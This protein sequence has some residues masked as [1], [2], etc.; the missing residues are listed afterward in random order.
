MGPDYG[1]YEPPQ[2]TM[3]RCS[4]RQALKFLDS[5]HVDPKKHSVET[6][7]EEYNLDSEKVAKILK[8]FRMHTIKIL[9]DPRQKARAARLK[10]SETK[11][12]PSGSADS[13]QPGKTNAQEPS[14]F[15]GKTDESPKSSSKD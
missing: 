9:E 14:L 7:G 3:G 5:H 15:W 1:Y 10:A 6:I 13:L 2:I 11:D 12:L 8:Y 4:I